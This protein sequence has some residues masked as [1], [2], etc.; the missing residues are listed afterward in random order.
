M[1]VSNSRDR[2]QGNQ[3]LSGRAETHGRTRHV[4][5]KALQNL[6]RAMVLLHLLLE[7]SEVGLQC[8]QLVQFKRVRLLHPWFT[9]KHLP[10][11]CLA[12][13]V[14]VHRVKLGRLD[15]PPDDIAD[16]GFSA[17]LAAEIRLLLLVIFHGAAR[18][19]PMVKLPDVAHISSL[20]FSQE[21]RLVDVLLGINCHDL[22]TRLAR[23]LRPPAG[24][25]SALQG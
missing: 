12:L 10:H 1:A 20:F 5:V 25:L 24:S 6:L 23:E 19:D 7:L 13:G 2:L 14:L 8:L 15:E 9:R 18:P 17:E 22:I 3:M 4:G 11:L 21:R 16:A